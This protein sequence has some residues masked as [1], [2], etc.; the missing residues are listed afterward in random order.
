MLAALSKW[1][2]LFGVARGSVRKSSAN[3]IANQRPHG[4]LDR[5]V[6]VG[7]LHQLEAGQKKLNFLYKLYSTTFIHHCVSTNTVVLLVYIATFS[8]IRSPCFTYKPQRAQLPYSIFVAFYFWPPLSAAKSGA[9]DSDA[10]DSAKA[11]WI[12]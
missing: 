10:F 8:A 7:A 9:D 3:T 5:V 12:I 4:K 11:Y 1:A 2:S 6:W